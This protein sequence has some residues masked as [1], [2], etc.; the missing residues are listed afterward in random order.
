MGTGGAE[1]GLDMANVLKPALARGLSCIGA[2]TPGEYRQ[3]I[4]PDP[5]FV[6]R[7]QVL[8]ACT[9]ALLVFVAC[10][11]PAALDDDAMVHGCTPC[12]L[13]SVL[14]APQT[15]RQPLLTALPV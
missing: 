2:T 14:L 5:A 7:F 11:M 1:G 13:L 10:T 6:R 9:P 15:A 3:R 8:E 12:R 4:E